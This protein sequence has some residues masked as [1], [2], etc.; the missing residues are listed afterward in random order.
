MGRHARFVTS[1]FLK[2][3]TDESDKSKGAILT[4]SKQ[5]PVLAFDHCCFHNVESSI[6]L[7]PKI[8]NE[9][10]AA[11]EVTNMKHSMLLV[12]A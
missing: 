11:E 2:R 7:A 6:S 3:F 9:V 4:A 8:H 5:M 10:K 1:M 12:S